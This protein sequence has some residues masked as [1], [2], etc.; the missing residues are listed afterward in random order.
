MERFTGDFVFNPKSSD[1]FRIDQVLEVLESGTGFMMIQRSALERF[2]KAYPEARYLP[3]HVGTADFDS[4][5]EIAMYF[6]AEIDPKS[7]RY[8]SEDYWFCQKAQGAG[9]KV[10]LCPWMNNIHIG[11]FLFK[12][13][14]LDTAQLGTA[15]Q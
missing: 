2:G 10:W 4:S 5:R 3:D 8:L 14:M 1:A 13:S 9:I 11:N 6:Q 15:S 7:K 12:G